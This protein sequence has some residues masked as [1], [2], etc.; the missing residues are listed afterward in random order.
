MRGGYP[1]S[2]GI[3]T[4]FVTLIEYAINITA[5]EPFRFG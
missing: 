5:G 1:V 2:A 4:F 3:A